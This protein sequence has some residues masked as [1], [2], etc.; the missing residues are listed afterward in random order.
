MGDLAELWRWGQFGRQSDVFDVLQADAKDFIA[1]REEDAA[2]GD[3][4]AAVDL[5]VG[6]AIACGEV[7]FVQQLAFFRTW[8]E[9]V[10]ERVHFGDVD[11]AVGQHGTAARISAVVVFP[12][13]LAGLA[14]EAVELV[15]RSSR[16]GPTPRRGG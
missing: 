5:N 12:V 11:F 6:N 15:P 14:V 7:L 16:T 2:I 10:E 8:L 1:G 13:L 3:G 4:G 9:N